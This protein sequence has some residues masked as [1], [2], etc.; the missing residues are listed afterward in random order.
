VAAFASA[1]EHL[2][3]VLE[4]VTAV[5]ER[6]IVV[7]WESG[8]LLRP[9]IVDARDPVDQLFA[10]G[11]TISEPAAVRIRDLDSEIARCERDLAE[12]GAPHLPLDRLRS[13][14][15]LSPTE[16]RV[17]HIALAAEH[18]LHIRNL[19]R[20]LAADI[21]RAALDRTM[22]ETLVY[23]R[24][25]RARLHEELGPR[26]LLL[27]RHLLEVMPGGE[28]LMFE[29]LRAAP[30]VVELATGV[31][32]VAPELEDVLHHVHEPHRFEELVVPADLR[33]QLTG[34]VQPSMF[35]IKPAIVV[36]GPTG[37]GRK[38]LLGA[39]ARAAGKGVVYIRSGDLPRQPAA[40]L[41]A[42]RGA[43]REAIVLDAIPVFV[44]V[45]LI[46]EAD[47]PDRTRERLLDAALAT[48]QSTV[49][50]T[51]GHGAAQPLKIARG[52]IVID[53]P[54]LTEAEREAMW[55]SSLASIGGAA[56]DTR[57]LAARYPV[58]PGMLV[59]ASAAA[60]AVAATRDGTITDEDIQLGLRSAMDEAVSSL[61][62]RI[63]RTQRWEDLVAPPDVMASLEELVARIKYRRRVYD[64]WGFA[65]K[66]TKGLGLSALFTGP[67]G[68]GKTMAATL[69][70]GQLA[71]DIYQVDVSRLVS[72]FI[73]E[74]EKN[75]GQIFDAAELGQA[76]ILFDEADAIFAK[77][78]EVKSSVDRYANLE[79]NY[80][81]QRLER[82]S[83]IAILTTNLAS[84]IDAAFKRRISFTIEFPMPD[85]REREQIWR[86]HLPTQAAV[87]GDLDFGYLARRHEMSGGHIR[88]AVLRAAFFAAAAGGPIRFE[89]LKR[90]GEIE[91]IA[92]GRVA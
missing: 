74:T 78:G 17:L 90:A 4:L 22:L 18:S 66:Y 12:R 73:G 38:T 30:R 70:A 76:I 36:A 60:A 52:T 71:L 51:A 34:L 87:E 72:K 40:F 67:P 58:T 85:E 42:V 23:G 64:E 77:R 14:F 59:H 8:R 2:D 24:A 15:G 61:G 28:S 91:A 35:S 55:K 49:A 39:A 10:R 5:I 75:L 79:V 47:A 45:H 26:S 37:S 20:Y 27:E 80:L 48:W 16:E 9:G 6:Q 68:T 11:L 50:A 65:D 32:R 63:A 89:H 31:V 19:L 46:A 86:T 69:I 84:S 82:F 92:M 1:L 29:G 44:D 21:R 25:G 88:N 53:V 62:R 33:N 83:G 54:P 3:V 57:R 7:A 56:L 13:A 41:A 81:L 43:L